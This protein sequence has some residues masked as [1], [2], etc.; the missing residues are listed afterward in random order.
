MTDTGLVALLK[1]EEKAKVDR[2]KL[3]YGPDVDVPRKPVDYVCEGLTVSPGMSIFGGTGFSGKTTALQSM[4]LSVASGKMVWDR[5]PSV[6]GN[7]IHID[8]EQGHDLTITKYQRMARAMGVSLSDL[9]IKLACSILPDTHM[10]DSDESKSDIQWLL[11]GRSLAVIDAFRGAFPDA[12]ENDSGVRK[13]LDMLHRIGLDLGCAVIVI[14]HCRK[15]SE[16]G[17]RNSLRGSG[18][19]FDAAQVVWMLE[20]TTAE[21][22]RAEQ[23]KQRLTGKIVEPMGLVFRDVMGYDGVDH[24]WGLEVLAEQDN[25]SG[26]G[27]RVS[28][29]DRVSMNAE[30]VASLS[31]RILGLLRPVGGEGTP[32]QRLVSLLKGIASQRDIEHCL[33]E[34]ILS[35]CVVAESGTKTYWLS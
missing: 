29:T 28:D 34:A 31:A 23:F 7:V 35:G 11:D 1:A 24:R 14:A 16:D 32:L 4:L 20:G 25:S 12:Q 9:G 13:Y 22:A 18:A 21:H 19:L 8:Y 27:A 6:S 26:D 30:R 33:L 15:S 3:Y 17:L 2:W 5:F 10:S